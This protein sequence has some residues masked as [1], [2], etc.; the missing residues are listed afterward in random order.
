M[1]IY[2]VGPD[3]LEDYDLN[4]VGGYKEDHQQGDGGYEWVVYWYENEY[5]EGYGQAVALRKDGLVEVKD[6]SHCSCYGPME[7]WATEAS[8]ISVEELLRKKDNV[9]DLQIREE[10]EEKV[11]QLIS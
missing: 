6:L 7:H 2:D 5:Y 11:R 4:W 1:K 9:H 3:K 8:T 10:V